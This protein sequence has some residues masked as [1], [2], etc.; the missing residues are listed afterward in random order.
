VLFKMHNLPPKFNQICRLCLT[1]V[2]P[3]DDGDEIIRKLSIFNNNDNGQATSHKHN[4]NERKGGGSE[5]TRV[6]DQLSKKAKRSNE[7]SISLSGGSAN[8]MNNGFSDDNSDGNIAERIMQCL[9]IKVS[10]TIYIS[11]TQFYE[12]K[13]HY[14]SSE[15]NDIKSI[16]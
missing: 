14:L 6:D 15:Q 2:E 9:S 4:H 13:N 8:V 12:K 7:I 1:L 10:H 11:I 5:K 3:K 16:T